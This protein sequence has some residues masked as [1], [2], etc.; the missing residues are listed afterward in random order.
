VIEALSSLCDRTIWLSAIH[1]GTPGCKAEFLLDF[2]RHC[3]AETIYLVGD[4]VDGTRRWCRVSRCEFSTAFHTRCP[5]Y[6]AE[7]RLLPARLTY[8]WL[9]RFHA[10]AGAVMVASG[11][12]G[13]RERSP[14]S[15]PRRPEGAAR[16]L[17]RLCVELYLVRVCEAVSR[18]SAADE[19]SWR[20][21]AATYAAA[22]AI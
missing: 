16:A 9:H 6:L 12:V 8:V 15:V 11:D 20:R 1:L 2:L 7:R 21:I 13:T 4:I 17:A 18:Q 10:P 3:E 5:E 19:L 14:D 22:A